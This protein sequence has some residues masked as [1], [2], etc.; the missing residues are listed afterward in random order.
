M[1]SG[2]SL[3]IR[4]VRINIL[5][6]WQ[7]VTFLPSLSEREELAQKLVNLLKENE[8]LAPIE[9]VQ[10]QA[11]NFFLKIPGLHKDGT[12]VNLALISPSTS[13][14]KKPVPQFNKDEFYKNMA[15]YFSE[16]PVE[17]L[18]NILVSLPP[19]QLA[20]SEAKKLISGE[21]DQIIVD[22]MNYRVIHCLNAICFHYIRWYE[23]L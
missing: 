19:S 21:V 16:Q 5:I 10:N 17:K 14:D 6:N 12:P 23:C 2:F 18:R 9:V 8:I 13:E 20:S 15:S 22:F 1:N 11:G 4:Q 3:F 7:Y